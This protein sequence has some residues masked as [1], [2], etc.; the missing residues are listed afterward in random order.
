MAEESWEFITD[1]GTT[2]DLN[3]GAYTVIDYDKAGQP[4]PEIESLELPIAGSRI[5]N[6]RY[7]QREQDLLVRIQTNSPCRN[8]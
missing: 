7:P 8:R 1:S 5:V 4:D 3:A 6:V 2:I